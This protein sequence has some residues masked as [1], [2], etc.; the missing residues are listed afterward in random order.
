[1]HDLFYG[2]GGRRA[3]LTA[4]SLTP[5]QCRKIQQQWNDKL[6]LSFPEI[7]DRI[8]QEMFT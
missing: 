3:Y 5:V 2:Y 4:L 8:E 7:A 1:M 6:N